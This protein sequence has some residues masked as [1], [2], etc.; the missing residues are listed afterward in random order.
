MA[1]EPG[2]SGS[3]TGR[4]KSMCHIPVHPRGL[5]ADLDGTFEVQRQEDR[6][7]S[8]MPVRKRGE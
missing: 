1:F 7:E 6:H 3:N 4:H 5:S 2:P 8:K